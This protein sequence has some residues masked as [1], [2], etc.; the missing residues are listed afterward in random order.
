MLEIGKYNTLEIAK[1]VDFGV[2][3]NSDDGEILLPAKYVPENYEVG[4][5]LEVFIYRDS[6][7]RIIATTLR[8]YAQAGEF[9]YLKVKQV[10]SFGAFMDWGLEKDLLVPL[11]NQK[12][13]LQEG[14][15][16]IVYVYLDESSDRIVGTTKIGKYLQNENIDVQEGDKADLM[17][18]GVTD[19]GIKVII[20]NKYLGMLYSNEV[21]RD[22]DIGERVSGYIKKI[23]EDN[24]IDVT[25]QKAG[26][27]EVTDAAD[28][29][30]NKLRFSGGYLELTDKSDPLDIYETLGMSKKVFKKAIGSLYKQ[31]KIVLEPNQIRLA[32]SAEE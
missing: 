27:D 26:Y 9:A 23:R 14:R 30:M 13:L 3:L 2:Y 25:L 16:Y 20:N 21:F 18:A 6:E 11:H 7:D 4:Q 19:L 17:V 31:G 29:I 8:P 5:M 28:R 12:D 24:K 15:H 1:T 32:G 10:A 22:L